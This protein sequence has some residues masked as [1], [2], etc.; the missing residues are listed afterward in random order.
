MKYPTFA[1]DRIRYNQ[2][3]NSPSMVQREHDQIDHA[4]AEPNPYVKGNRIPDPNRNSQN[5]QE[6]KNPINQQ[7]GNVVPNV[8]EILEESN[9]N[10]MRKRSNQQRQHLFFHHKRT[11]RDFK[12]NEAYWKLYRFLPTIYLRNQPASKILSDGRL[13]TKV[14]NMNRYQFREQ[15]DLLTEAYQEYPYVSYE[16]LLDILNCSHNRKDYD[17]ESSRA[18][19][20]D[21][22]GEFEMKLINTLRMIITYRK[23]NLKERNKKPNQDNHNFY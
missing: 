10:G 4:T 18:A 11:R 22:W 14:Y 15:F 13:C 6:K 21:E 1:F 23:E 7:S 17:F 20:S 12:K 16:Y 19:V 8:D 5:T 9:N 2:P 3:S